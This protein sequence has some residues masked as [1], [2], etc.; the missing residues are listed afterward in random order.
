MMTLADTTVAVQ[1]DTEDTLMTGFEPSDA[2]ALWHAAESAR[3]AEEE[4]RQERLDEIA[5]FAAALAAYLAEHG[6]SDEL[7]L[8]ERYA[9]L[10]PDWEEQEL[11]EAGL[12]APGVGFDVCH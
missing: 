9:E 3:R 6:G 7:T 11:S 4:A 2:D 10:E 5:A 1:N 8:A 12:S